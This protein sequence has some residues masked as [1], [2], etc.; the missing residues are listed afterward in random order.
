[1]RSAPVTL[2]IAYSNGTPTSQTPVAFGYRK[3]VRNDRPFVVE[4]PAT[5][6]N[7]TVA[8]TYEI[9]QQPTKAVI[10]GGNGPYRL[11]RP[12]AGA[13][14][15]DTLQFRVTGAGTSATVP[16][17][18]DF[19]VRPGD[20]NCDGVVDFKDIN[21]FVLLLTDPAGWQTA[22]PNCPQENGDANGDGVVDF[23]D[24]NPFVALL[25]G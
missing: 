5:F 20:L 12:N 10:G 2:S 16:V 14:G 8:L 4:L 3:F 15:V 9:T 1:M 23:K 7:S 18:I 21:P 22:Y 19:G 6:D 13:K 25:A 11:L 24:I 17:V